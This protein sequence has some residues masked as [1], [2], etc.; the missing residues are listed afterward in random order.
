MEANLVEPQAHVWKYIFKFM[1][2][3]S[4]KCAVQLGIFDVIHNHG[5]PMSLSD[6]VSAL[7]VRPTKA[8]CLGRL[9]RLLVHSDF[10]YATNNDKDNKEE[11]KYILTP[12][13]RLLL[14]NEPQGAAT[15][16]LLL[17]LDQALSG[18][19]D[20]LSGW[21]GSDDVTPFE[22]GNGETI[23]DYVGGE[24]PFGRLFHETMVSDSSWLVMWW[25]ENVVVFLRD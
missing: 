5:G 8:Q 16:L 11:I 4:L 23:W 3:L 10:L 25:L 2:S 19:W 13:S 15:P 14:K 1:D 20:S 21:F 9:M 7:Y 6:L 24:A 18:P 17:M 22:M 12:L